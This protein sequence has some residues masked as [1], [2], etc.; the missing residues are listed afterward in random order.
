MTKKLLFAGVLTTSLAILAL[1]AQPVSADYY[2]CNGVLKQGD[3]APSE[4]HYFL[5]PQRSSTSDRNRVDITDSRDTSSSRDRAGIVT[6]A[7]SSTS[8]V[9]DYGR[10]RINITTDAYNTATSTTNNYNDRKRVSITREITRN[11]SD[12]EEARNRPDAIIEHDPDNYSKKYEVRNARKYCIRN[13]CYIIY[14]YCYD[15]THC[16]EKVYKMPR[17]EGQYEDNW[18]D[19]LEDYLDSYFDR[20]RPERCNPYGY[21]SRNCIYRGFYFGGFHN[22]YWHY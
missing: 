17:E 8:T 3:P 11:Y 6:D 12:L 14:D 1:V 2:D 15:L 20:Y 19:K 18:R 13:Y 5:S 10:N 4:C 21:S 7:T 16:E 22:G 9:D